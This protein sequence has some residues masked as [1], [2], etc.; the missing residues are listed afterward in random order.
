MNV[1]MFADAVRSPEFNRD[2]HTVA[3]P[4]STA[5]RRLALDGDSLARD[6]AYQEIPNLDVVPVEDYG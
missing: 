1:L 2:L 6:A 4:S 5:G 3:D